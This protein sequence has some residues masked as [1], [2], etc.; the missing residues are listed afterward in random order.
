MDNSSKINVLKALLKRDLAYLCCRYD[1]SW[2]KPIVDT[3]RGLRD[4][5][6]KAVFFGGTIR[7]LLFSRLQSGSLGRPRDVDIVVAEVTL[8]DLRKKFRDIISRETRFGGLQLLRN[9]WHFDIW[10]LNRTWAFEKDRALP[11]FEALPTTTFFNLEAIAV[12]VWPSRGTS[13]ITYSGDEQ[14]FDGVL[15]RT[16]EIN[17]EEN[18]YPSLCI[19]RALVLASTVDL[20]IGPILARYLAEHSVTITNAELVAVQ[21][22]HYGSLRIPP[23]SLRSWLDNIC[24]IVDEKGPS[25]IRLPILRQKSL[26]PLPESEET[27]PKLN[28]YLER[29]ASTIHADVQDS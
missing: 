4:E 26:W 19:V 16:L 29:A 5:H 24:R 17:R 25:V 2:S 1:R 20:K 13:R 14:F 3:L 18:P 7:S 22:K 8:E 15:N 23:D 28:Q 9:S 12:Q 21:Q 11:T 6:S 27:W 10:P